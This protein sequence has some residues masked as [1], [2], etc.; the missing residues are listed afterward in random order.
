LFCW[1]CRVFV[2]PLLGILAEGGEEHIDDGNHVAEDDELRTPVKGGEGDRG[3]DDGG[4]Y[5]GDAEM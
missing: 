5:M 1:K 4:L 3:Q 2:E